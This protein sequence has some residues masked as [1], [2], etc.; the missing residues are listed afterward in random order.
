MTRHDSCSYIR[1]LYV[2]TRAR[3]RDP[4]PSQSDSGLPTILDWFLPSYKKLDGP[5]LPDSRLWLF[6]DPRPVGVAPRPRVPR[7]VIP[8]G[9]RGLPRTSVDPEDS[10]PRQDRRTAHPPTLT[11]PDPVTTPG[12]GG[13]TR[14]PQDRPCDPGLV[15]SSSSVADQSEV[16]GCLDGRSGDPGRPEPVEKERPGGS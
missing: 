10:E 7:P 1:V 11:E 2:T 6:C 12:S 3:S 8:L 5:D 16:G 13:R 14:D 4:S 9:H 15:P